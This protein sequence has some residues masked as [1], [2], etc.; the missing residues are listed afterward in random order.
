MTTHTPEPP[1]QPFSADGERIGTGSLP[2]LR[3]LEEWGEADGDSFSRREKARTDR[4]VAIRSS[5]RWCSTRLVERFEH[6]AARG[7]LEHPNI[8]PL[9][10]VGPVRRRSDIYFVMKLLRGQSCPPLLRGRAKLDPG[11]VRRFS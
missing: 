8:V 5:G 10:W 6:E 7:T 3:V 2:R 1:V 11:D 4:E 9:R